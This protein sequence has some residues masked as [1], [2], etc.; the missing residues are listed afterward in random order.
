[1]TLPIY[2]LRRLGM[3]RG[4]RLTSSK[5][6]EE[7]V[8]T[9][10][11]CHKPVFRKT[12][13]GVKQVTG[14]Y[15]G[16][17]YYHY[18]CQP[19]QEWETYHRHQSDKVRVELGNLSQEEY[20]YWIGYVAKASTWAQCRACRTVTYSAREREEH[21]KDKNF[22]VGGNQCTVRLVN[23]YK[24]MLTSTLCV[25]CKQ[26]RWGGQK[27]GVPLCDRPECEKLWKFDMTKW[28][29]WLINSIAKREPQKR[30]R[31]AKSA[32]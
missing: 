11:A 31:K 32:S 10:P 9:C 6:P 1:M 13:L 20:R 24:I 7:V 26:Q 15:H 29:P 3:P 30:W 25:V 17:D 12:F 23:A 4:H 19:I 22:L 8:G 2:F 27:W 21:F 5:P 16:T 28:Q 14:I 18:G